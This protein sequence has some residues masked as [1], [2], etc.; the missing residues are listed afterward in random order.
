[1]VVCKGMLLIDA[2]K[3]K[4]SLGWSGSIARSSNLVELG[5]R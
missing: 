1:M 4:K 3:K 5:L 2:L